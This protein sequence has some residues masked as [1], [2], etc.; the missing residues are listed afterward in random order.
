[1]F[2]FDLCGRIPLRS[3]PARGWIAVL[4]FT[5]LLPA[6]GRAAAAAGA[7]TAPDY[8]PSAREFLSE[9]IDLQKSA[10]IGPVGLR[11]PGADLRLDGG[12]LSF[13]T[14]VRGRVRALVY[15]GPGTF[16]FAPPSAFERAEVARF[17]GTERLERTISRVVFVF[18]D[19]TET[20]MA[21]G[22]T[23]GEVSMAKDAEEGL[24]EYLR[25]MG[26]RDEGVLWES[27]ARPLLGGGQRGG[28]FAYI[29]C[30]DGERMFYEI[31]P[32]Q[33]EDV[34]FWRVPRSF[35]R[36]WSLD[37]R[38]LVSRFPS[39]SARA[40]AL[41]ADAESDL[42][43]SH[44]GLRC[45]IAGTLRFSAT[46][47]LAVRFVEDGPRWVS[48]QLYSGLDVD[49]V[50]WDG[51]AATHFRA[52]QSPVLWVRT[53]DHARAGQAASLR[54][55]YQGGLIGSAG[56][57]LWLRSSVGWYPWAP[58]ARRATFDLE[59]E[60]PAKFH[61]SASGEKTEEQE[62]RGVRR[63]RWSVGAPT[64]NVTLVIGR[65]EERAF[66]VEGAGTVHG[67]MYRGK[68]DRVYWDL[69]G[70]TI[71]MGSPLDDWVVKDAARA[72][73][74]FRSNFGAPLVGT[75]RVAQVPSLH[76][77]AFPGLINIP[78]TAYVG[79]T[80][81]AE[82][83]VFRAHEVAHQWWGFGVGMRTYRDHWL[84]EGFANFAGLWYLQEG[85][86][87]QREYLAVL[88]RWRDRL[89]EDRR[90]RPDGGRIAGPIWLGHRNRTSARPSDYVLVDYLKGA[91]VL[92]MLRTM[93]LDLRT[94]DDGGFAR[95]MTE[96]YGAHRGGDASTEDFRRVAESVTGRDLGWFFEQW[97]YGA[98]IPQFGVAQ[99]IEQ[100]EDGRHV[101]RLRVSPRRVPPG[102]R[103][104]VVIRIDFG[105]DRF[106]W[107]S[108]E[109]GDSETELRLPPVDSKPVA[110]IF[111]DVESVLAEVKE[112]AW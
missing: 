80:A 111:N 11:R 17:F 101:V 45:R 12:T 110:V 89:L 4:A 44:L 69:D 40:G 36:L 81:T 46:A 84:I 98:E 29:R 76:G 37:D 94:M 96:F 3:L 57:W 91:W 13:A 24:R 62:H 5:V 6:P 26:D 51:V 22:I 108:R 97:V 74:F 99:R 2:P 68:P 1:M 107:V 88:R 72:S 92:H 56:E 73:A 66:N 106:A 87:S 70:T 105:G 86:G 93:L 27:V 102:F 35:T 85:L 53:P 49:S 82:D 25:L 32:D 79:E 43:L 48:L 34:T 100:T 58:G 54:V 78:E 75:L 55:G 21:G 90:T 31:R 103:M 41:Q 19:S 77:E 20:E 18:F 38:D 104:P 30:T 71:T 14:P 67:L 61:L 64:R 52:R 15:T 39:D 95:I 59:V 63:T 47:D 60:S 33:R 8:L 10:R 112:T 16:H 7:E 9:S 42:E 109:V 50:S 28:F 83:Q 23:G 65:F